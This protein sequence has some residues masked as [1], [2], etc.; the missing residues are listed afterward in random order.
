ME[1]RLK[2]ILRK[3]NAE[4]CTCGQE[5]SLG[6]IAWNEGQSEAGTPASWVQIVCPACQRE[7][8]WVHSWTWFDEDLSD[9]KRIEK[10]LT[11]LEDDWR[12][13]RWRGLP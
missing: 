7:I 2:E 11:I 4:F 9:S 3:H 1:N 6:D 12:E 5:I 8:A 10:V 13:K